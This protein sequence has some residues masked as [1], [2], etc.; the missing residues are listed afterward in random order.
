M[1][2]SPPTALVAESVFLVMIRVLDGNDSAPVEKST[3]TNVFPVVEPRMMLTSLLV[4]L[5]MEPPEKATA[6]FIR[7]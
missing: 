4:K 7:M 3:L 1:L 5:K 2:N 6:G